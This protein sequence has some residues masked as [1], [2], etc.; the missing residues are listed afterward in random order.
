MSDVRKKAVDAKLRNMLLKA[1]P[2]KGYSTRE[3]ANEVGLTHQRISQIEAQ[4]L[5][6]LRHTLPSGMISDLIAE[7]RKG[8]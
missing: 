6:K 8:D 2:G 7:L 1:E 3:I 4:A 5:R